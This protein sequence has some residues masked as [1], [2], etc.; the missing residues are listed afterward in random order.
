[1]ENFMKKLSPIFVLIFLVLSVFSFETQAFEDQ[2]VGIDLNYT[3]S[4]LTSIPNSDAAYADFISYL[5]EYQ[6][7]DFSSFPSGAIT[8]AG[9]TINFTTGGLA[10]LKGKAWIAPGSGSSWE[11]TNPYTAPIFSTRWYSPTGLPRFLL[12]ESQGGSFT[13][14]FTEPITAFGFYATDFD[15]PSESILQFYNESDVKVLEFFLR[16]DYKFGDQENAPGSVVF[17]GM[18]DTERPF[19]R[20]TFYGQG[21]A[22][23]LAFDSFFFA[24]EE[25][26]TTPLPN[27]P[28]VAD[29]TSITVPKDSENN[30]IG[31]NA[32]TDPDGNPLTITVTRIPLPSEG[33]ITKAD[34]ITPLSVDDILTPEEV[35]GLQFDAAPGFIG[36]V[37]PFTYTVSDGIETVSGQADITVIS[38]DPGND[39]PEVFDI[40]R[41][42]PKNTPINFVADDFKDNF[43]DPDGDSLTQIKVTSLPLNGTLELNVNG[44]LVA[45]NV[46]D[47]IAVEDLDNL[48]FT[49]DT[50][51]TGD[52]TFD[53][54]G[55]DGTTYATADA[56]VN[57]TIRAEGS[58]IPPDSQD[59]PDSSAIPEPGTLLLIGLGLLG[60]IALRRRR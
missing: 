27:D 25:Q 36:P 56:A 7:G 38:D 34:G 13:I 44:T 57:I 55:Y 12:V 41:S 46:N 8:S 40:S 17:F 52:T 45:V 3:G 50:D 21:E 15:T 29:S 53:W 19:R 18:I 49:P 43:S 35:A 48:V 1:M 59:P 54:N 22:N 16:K 4:P 37:T 24:T 39:P 26:A 47:E 60:L 5:K 6:V 9:V 11:T 10:T 33:T 2:F 32:P 51:W 20:L 14:E 42:R 31:L 58:T 30:G 23:L 28:P